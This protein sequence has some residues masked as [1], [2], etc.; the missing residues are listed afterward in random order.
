M[1]MTLNTEQDVVAHL[2]HELRSGLMGVVGYT[3]L[4]EQETCPHIQKE[5]LQALQKCS[6]S[7]L[8]FTERTLQDYRHRQAGMNATAIT[9]ADPAILCPTNLVQLLNEAM[10]VVKPLAID[11]GLTLQARPSDLLP[12][13]LLLPAVELNQLMIN[14]LHNA[15]KYTDTGSVTIAAAWQPDKP[16]SHS[17]QLCLQ[18]IDS[19]Q[20]IDAEKL[21]SLFMPWKRDAKP[22]QHG[23]G[24]GLYICLQLS[25]S[26]GAE[27][28]ANPLPGQGNCFELQLPAARAEKPADG[29]NPLSGIQATDHD[30]KP[31]CSSLQ[32]KVTVL[33]ADDEHVC[34]K[35]TSLLIQQLI[36]HTE[37]FMAKDGS[38]ALTMWHKHQPQLVLL[39]VSMP[40]LDG[41][42][43]TKAIRKHEAT[44]EAKQ[45]KHCTIIG[46]SGNDNP[47]LSDICRKAGMN[48]LL[49]KPLTLTDLH[50]HIK[51]SANQGGR[52]HG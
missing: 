32:G 28:S 43:V 16:N 30:E 21:P 40:L 52:P 39:D 9:T 49:V 37:V 2:C 46:I 25:N 29:N 3:E 13:Y 1:D 23:H 36:P 8:H 38:Q 19:A 10:S 41:L 24:L 44:R 31:D 50:Q 11:K 7:L 42:A 15:I 18:V 45:K 6:R 12:Q 47:Q 5:Y 20:C 22:G 34:C 14:L 35:I 33:V 48:H 27:L 51:E 17:G 4:L 26:I